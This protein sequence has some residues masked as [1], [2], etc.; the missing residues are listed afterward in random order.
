LRR[1]EKQ[2]VEG[3]DGAKK[4]KKKGKRKPTEDYKIERWPP[5]GEKKKRRAL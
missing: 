4:K 3:R 5:R 1:S 2:S